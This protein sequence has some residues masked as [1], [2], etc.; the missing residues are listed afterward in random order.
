MIALL[1]A[2]ATQAITPDIANL[3]SAKLFRIL[4]DLCTRDAGNATVCSSSKGLAEQGGGVRPWRGCAPIDDN[5]DEEEAS[6]V[7]LVPGIEA[8]PSHLLLRRRAE[9][10][11][12]VLHA[13]GLRVSRSN[14]LYQAFIPRS[15]ISSRP[16]IRTLCRMTC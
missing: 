12:H 16:L 5:A 8:S 2:N 3:A 10:S 13:L 15:A 4:E 6:D 14:D 11:S 9:H 1:V 7:C